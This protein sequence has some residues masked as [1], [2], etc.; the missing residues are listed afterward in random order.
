MHVSGRGRP[1]KQPEAD[2]L[3]EKS[4]ALHLCGHPRLSNTVEFNSFGRGLSF[5]AF[6]RNTLNVPPPQTPMLV[7][8]IRVQFPSGWTRWSMRKASVFHSLGEPRTSLGRSLV[9]HSTFAPTLSQSCKTRRSFGVGLRRR[10][11]PFWMSKRCR[12]CRKRAVG[13]RRTRQADRVRSAQHPPE[14]PIGGFDLSR[15]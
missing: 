11:L 14:K 4:A 10:T 1:P 5:S 2:A 8:V 9:V 3:E 13:R 6:R 15:P 12:G 7:P